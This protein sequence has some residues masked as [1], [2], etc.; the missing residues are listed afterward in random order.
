MSSQSY[1]NSSSSTIPKEMQTVQKIVL[2]GLNSRH[3]KRVY[4]MAIQNF[5]DYWVELGKPIPDKLFL[6]TYIFDRQEQGIGSASLNLRLAAIKNF[7]REAADL[8]VWP[9]EVPTV[10]SRVKKIPTRGSRNG[11]WLTLE[12]A[13]KLIDAPNV[14][15]LMGKRDRAILSILLGC[16]LRR[17][18]LTSLTVDHL[19][20][21]NHIWVLA[22]ILG[23]RN[24]LRTVVVPDWTM[25]ALEVYIRTADISTDYIFRPMTKNDKIHGDCISNRTLYRVVKLYATKCGLPEIA[26]HDLRRTYAKLAYQNG[27]KLDQIQINLGHQSL[28]TTQRYLGI[29]LDLEDGPGNY[30]DIR[31]E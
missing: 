28:T 31:I 26:P 6:Q 29:E 2:N 13:Q 3:S 1:I 25:R 10:F 16:G 15:T 8:K 12:Q 14:K 18:E 5:L 23:K 24:K 9:D 17:A 20:Q 22:N 4:R 30:L 21:R 11:N 7:A 27:A 19:Q